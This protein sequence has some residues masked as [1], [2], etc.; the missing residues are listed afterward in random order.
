MENSIEWFYDINYDQ[1]SY[2]QLFN[3]DEDFFSKRI[4]N[5]L[6][7]SEDKSF[8]IFDKEEYSDYNLEEIFEHIN[9]SHFNDFFSENSLDIPRCFKD[10]LSLRRK[11]NELLQ[12]K[13]NNYI[14]REGKRYKTLKFLNKSIESILYPGSVNGPFYSKSSYE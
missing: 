6:G 4:D 14:M 9:Y 10:S 5:S 1:N 11:S 12:I 7:V 8:Y 3:M 13:L 2:I